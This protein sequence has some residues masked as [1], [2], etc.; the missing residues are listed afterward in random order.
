MSVLG[1]LSGS[2]ST[3]PY[4]TLCFN[5]RNPLVR[6]IADLK[7]RALIRRSV[8]MLYVQALLLG[9]HPLSSKEM[10]LLNSGLTGL[11]EWGISA[12]GKDADGDD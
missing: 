1:N 5:F 4:A 7:D 2:S 11:I 8:E 12:S 10:A 6:K 3:D 9:H